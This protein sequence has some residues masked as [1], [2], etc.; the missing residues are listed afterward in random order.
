MK[1]NDNNILE[2]MGQ[3]A[4]EGCGKTGV[5][6][7]L[8]GVLIAAI[9]FL[10][11]VSCNNNSSKP[12]PIKPIID[13]F[14]IKMF[15]TAQRENPEAVF[16]K[17]RPIKPVD[18]PKPT[19]NPKAIVKL[20]F[21]GRLLQN[22]NW[23]YNG[24]I[25]LDSSGLTTDQ[26]QEIINGMAADYT[27]FN[28]AFTMDEAVYLAAPSTRRIRIC[29]TKTWQ[30][31][32]VSGGQAFLGSLFWG[33]DCPALVFSMLLNYSTRSNKNNGDHELGHAIGLTHQHAYDSACNYTGEYN[34]G[35]AL[36]CWI[37]GF[38]YQ[39]DVRWKPL[40]C[41]PGDSLFISNAL[42]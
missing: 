16:Q 15:D 6:L 23:N 5:I 29:F 41:Q 33:T 20:E 35:N 37:M 30:P 18:P 9:I 22:T 39:Q 34:Y 10:L 36:Y 17:G 26:Q 11:C 8:S 1:N 40:G 4:Y 25:Q 28:I 32:G 27:P 21:N 13:S 31:V 12:K 14:G 42:K 38:P 19:P 2:D 7:F 24:P 3:G